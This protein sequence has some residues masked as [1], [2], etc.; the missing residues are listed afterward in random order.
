MTQNPSGGHSACP[1]LGL[2]GDSNHPINPTSSWER[3]EST[4]K[5][6]DDHPNMPPVALTTRHAGTGHN[7]HHVCSAGAAAVSASKV[8]GMLPATDHVGESPP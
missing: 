6:Q 7:L 1:S 8:K 5:S 4:H 3:G 2:R